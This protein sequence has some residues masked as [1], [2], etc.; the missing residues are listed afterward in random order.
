M[1]SDV[2]IV[3]GGVSGIFAA[4]LASKQRKVTIIEKPGRNFQLGKRILVSG[5]GRANFFN[6][7]ILKKETYS[8]PLF[9]DLKEVVFDEKGAWAE[10]TLDYLTQELG[11][12]Y[13][14]EGKLFYPFFNRS[15]CLYQLLISQLKRQQVNVIEG[16]VISVDAEKK[17]C[18]YLTLDRQKKTLY[19]ED[20]VIAT[21]GRSFD[22]PDYSYSLL[23]SLG[24]AYQDYSPCLCPIIVKERIPSYLRNNRLKGTVSLYHKKELI[25]QEEGEILFKED[26]LSGIAIFNTTVYINQLLDEHQDDVTLLLDYRKHDG[27]SITGNTSLDCYPSFL[28]QYLKDCSY[29]PGVPLKFTFQDLY[30]FK[31]SQ[32][33]YGG[34]S[35]KEIDLRTMQSKK[36]P[37]LYLCGE[38][39][40]QNFPCGGYNMGYSMVEGYKTGVSLWKNN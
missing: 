39:L 1:F 28:A 3:G 34:I 5:N 11:F 7:D 14:Q 13:Y 18:N 23:D 29:K 17:I 33:S 24:L 2:L 21:G 16:N 19:Y 36:K 30:S 35:L 4:L 31:Y 32:V 6:E 40:N 9:S 38:I 20:A 8:D 15:E 27:Y 26:G 10:K 25:H 12:S 37:S 22:R